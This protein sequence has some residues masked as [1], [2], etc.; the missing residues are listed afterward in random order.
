MKLFQKHIMHTKLDIYLSII[1]LFVYCFL[2]TDHSLII[3]NHHIIRM[4]YSV[5]ESQ[6]RLV[7][8]DID[9]IGS[10]KSNYRT[11]TTTAALYKH[12]YLI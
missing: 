9:C 3:V 11:T 2:F 10:C 4:M 7:V 8:I 1:L 6:R 5:T 12:V